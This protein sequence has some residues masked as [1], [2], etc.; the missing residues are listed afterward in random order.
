M[1]L[2]HVSHL[3]KRGLRY[4]SRLKLA[5]GVAATAA[6]LRALLQLPPLPAAR[7]LAMLNVGSQGGS[8]G[9][10]FFE[11]SMKQRKWAFVAVYGEEEGLKRWAQWYYGKK[12]KG[13]R[14]MQRHAHVLCLAGC[15]CGW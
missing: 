4:A 6:P 11:A 12:R 13:G 9:G 8:R 10:A 5:A 7:L 3:R 15:A 1:P 14:R 2:E